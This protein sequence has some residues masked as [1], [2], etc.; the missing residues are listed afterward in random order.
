MAADWRFEKSPH[1][2]IGGLRSYAGVPLKFETEFGQHMAFGSLC[3]A[4]NSPQEQLAPSVQQ[5][6]VRIA[7]AIVSD[8]VHSARARRQKERRRM[9]ELICDAQRLCDEHANMEEEIPKMLQEIYPDMEATIKRTT[10]GSISFECGTAFSTSD[11][12]QGLWEDTEYFDYAIKRLNHLDMTASRPVR[13]VA[14]RCA[15][16]YVPT[17]LVVACNDLK[18]VFDDVDSWFVQTCAVS[19]N[20]RRT[21]R[22]AIANN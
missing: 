14:I 8:I 4:S 22:I 2:E 17:F 12:E 21:I 10:D 11:L 7:D 13:A 19:S 1:V 18:R 15:S 9:L 6:L 3:V 5:G 20:R 16:Q